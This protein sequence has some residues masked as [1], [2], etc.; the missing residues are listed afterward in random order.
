M[1]F[2]FCYLSI[3]FFIQ[4][5]TVNLY[6]IRRQQHINADIDTVWDFF[7][8]PENLATLTPKELNFIT[9][10]QQEGDHIYPG[11][12]ITYTITPLFGIKLSWMTEIS[13]VQDKTMFV[14]EQR[15][16]PYKLWHHQHHFKQTDNGTLMTDI[17]HYSLPLSILGVIAHTLFVRKMLEDI[18]DYRHQKTEELFNKK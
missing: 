3:S 13:Q 15:K 1:S 7:S 10:S 8:N 12:V 18:F 11:Q 4:L 14:D 16:G 6:H 2:N 5:P 17:V 9:T